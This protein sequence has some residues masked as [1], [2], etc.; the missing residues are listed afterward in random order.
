MTNKLALG[1]VQFGSDYGYTRQTG[2]TEVDKIL[3]YCTQCG[4]NLLDTARDYGASELKIGKYLKRN[5]GHRFL[6]ATK[7]KKIDAETARNQS[8][9]VT[10]VIN[11]VKMSLEALG[12]DHIDLLQLHQT[13]SYIVHNEGFW[14]AVDH[15]K[16]QGLF[17]SFGVSI[18]EPQEGFDLLDN[19]QE[20]VD[21]IQ[22][23]YNVFDQ[24]CAPLFAASRFRQQMSALQHS[25]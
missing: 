8:R 2:Q 6:L 11:S 18:Y 10:H 21:V 17:H 7:I 16:K 22:A 15:V 5:R 24:R 23:P 25:H 9:L 20:F 4:I 1:T 19:F 14:Q 12:L 13:D 3:D